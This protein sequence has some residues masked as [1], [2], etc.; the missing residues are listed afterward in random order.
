MK[1]H[2]GEGSQPGQSRVQRDRR[3]TLIDYV[4]LNRRRSSTVA[5]SGERVRKAASLRNDQVKAAVYALIN[6]GRMPSSVTLGCSRCMRPIAWRATPGVETTDW[7]ARRGKTAHG[8]GRRGRPRR[9]LPLSIGRLLPLMPP[10]SVDLRRPSTIVRSGHVDLR[11][12]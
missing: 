11:R 3:G 12:S 5:V 2:V 1:H 9:S 6:D 8:F 7:R 4:Q 10:A